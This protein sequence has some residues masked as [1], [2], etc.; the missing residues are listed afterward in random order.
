MRK[1]YFII[2]L[3][4][5]IIAG[6][7]VW[8]CKH[9]T[10]AGI[11]EIANEG[12]SEDGGEEFMGPQALIGSGGGIVLGD[13][14]VLPQNSLSQEEQDGEY[15]PDFNNTIIFSGRTIPALTV[16]SNGVILATAGTTNGPI[17]IKRSSDMGKTWLETTVNG[18]TSGIG[19]IHP[20]FINCHNG[21]ILLGVT[22]N[23]SGS[24]TTIIYRGKDDGQNWSVA[25]NISFSEIC[26]DTK[27]C[28][29]TYGQGI[30]LRHGANANQNKLMFPYFYYNTTNGKFTATMLSGDDGATFSNN[31]NYVDKG[32]TKIAYGP[33]NTYE[34]KFLELCDGNVLLNM[35]ASFSDMSFWMKST[36]SGKTWSITTD[37]QKPTE[38]ENLKHADFTRYEFSGKDI[39]NNGSK[40]ALAI[41]SSYTG[42]SYTVKMTT[43]DFNNGAKNNKYHF[44]RELVS[45][46][47]REDGYPAIT[48]LPDGTI[49]TLTE[50]D[51]N[52]VFRRFN[53]SWLTYQDEKINYDIDLKNN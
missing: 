28:F 11:P 40:Y 50:E 20:F 17:T 22:S 45:E 26:K 41:Y 44:T 35:R 49:A 46:S 32:A 8:A 52:V 43:N 51:D 6:I 4:V 10:G 5:I 37:N 12:S 19:Y 18:T 31:C 15:D 23:N 48:V 30:T 53:L 7:L 29:V 38:S 33:F 24:K 14:Y 9:P 2:T 21:D 47:G 1:R 16:T 34:T 36:D 27:E 25:T 3:I 42:N 13:G 39:K